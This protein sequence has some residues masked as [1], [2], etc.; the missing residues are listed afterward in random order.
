MKCWK[1]KEKQIIKLQ[2][3]VYFIKIK[4]ASFSPL[5][6]NLEME[7]YEDYIAIIPQQLVPQ[8]EVPATD[9]I[10]GLGMFTIRWPDW[11]TI[12]QGFWIKYLYI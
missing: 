10:I 6:S 12:P 2:N 7:Q 3:K 8:Q 4:T 11:L 5:Q 1:E 9:K